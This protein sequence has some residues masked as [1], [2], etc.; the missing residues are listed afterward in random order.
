MSVLLYF[1][2]A[3][4]AILA[5]V[6][7]YYHVLLYRKNK[8][9]SVA[10]K[11]LAYELDERH[12]RNKNSIVIIARAVIDDQ[13]SLT[14]ASIR[15]HTISQSMQVADSARE[16]LSV[17]R[18]VAEATAHIPILEKWREL[19]KKQKAAYDLERAKVEDDFR[20][21]AVEAARKII[22]NDVEL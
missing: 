10:E 18:Q 3:I 11:A 14:E 2:L 4:V 20:E 22:N 5:A 21:F 15:I 19:P 16:A 1:G 17:F 12:K 9:A 6:A 8:K 7:G 13:V